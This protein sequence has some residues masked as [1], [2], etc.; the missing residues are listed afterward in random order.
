MSA[1]IKMQLSQTSNSNATSSNYNK[2]EAPV[3]NKK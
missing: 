3:E 1:Q 2:K